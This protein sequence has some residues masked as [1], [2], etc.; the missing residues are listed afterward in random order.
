MAKHVPRGVSDNRAARWQCCRIAT[1]VHAG[2]SAALG[3]AIKKTGCFLYNNLLITFKFTETM[4]N[5]FNG[6]GSFTNFV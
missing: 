6:D 2:G 3:P 5:F 1:A 4:L